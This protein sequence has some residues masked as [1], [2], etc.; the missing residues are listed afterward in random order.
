MLIEYQYGLVLVALQN[1][2]PHEHGGHGEGQ[3]L[4]ETN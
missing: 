2:E 1:H 4:L 3:P